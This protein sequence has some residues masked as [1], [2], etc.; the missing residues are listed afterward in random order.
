MPGAST[1][2]IGNLCAQDP[3]T[4]MDTFFLHW[5]NMQKFCLGFNNGTGVLGPI[6]H[7][8]WRLEFQVDNLVF[9]SA[10]GNCEICCVLQK[11]GAPHIHM[12]VWVNGAP[13]I[14]RDSVE[15]VEAYIGKHISC[16][17]PSKTASPRLYQLVR[18]VQMHKCSSSCMRKKRLSVARVV[19]RCKHNFP[20]AVSS[21]LV[22]N[23]IS[24]AIKSRRKAKVK[25]LYNLIRSVYEVNIN[26]YN[27]PILFSWGS[28]MVGFI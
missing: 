28:N 12:K 2:R 8:F 21:C 9:Y 25:R 14:G 3:K 6:D 11:R 13:V 7:W 22:L 20:R 10:M 1:A 5:D 15:V 18:D 4:V 27:A 17:L 23:S 19:T 24:E 16:R 26:D